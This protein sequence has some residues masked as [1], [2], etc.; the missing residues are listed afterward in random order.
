MLNSDFAA[1]RARALAGRLYREGGGR[2][3]AMID[4]AYRLVLAR[5]PRADEIVQARAFLDA[6]TA[7]LRKRVQ[8]GQPIAVPP[9]IPRNTE[10]AEA[11]AWVDFALAMLNRNEFVYVP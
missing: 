3:E 7:L 8:R 2:T 5:A 1:G 4:R 10:S 9:D 6:Q 11:A